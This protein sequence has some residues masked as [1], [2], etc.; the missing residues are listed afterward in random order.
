MD[1]P[2]NPSGIVYRAIKAEDEPALAR[3]FGTAKARELTGRLAT[4]FGA[5]AFA[6]ADGVGYSW[7]TTHPRKGEGEPPFLYDIAPKAGWSYIFGTHI[8]PAFRGRGMATALK[9]HLIAEARARG[10]QRAVCTHDIGNRPVIHVSEKLGF[11]PEGR[12]EYRRLLFWERRDL[13]GL[14]PAVRA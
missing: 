12:I 13:S 11:R 8:A 14:P 6:G 1:P 7:M 5:G 2:A 10:L 3:T 4:C 9:R